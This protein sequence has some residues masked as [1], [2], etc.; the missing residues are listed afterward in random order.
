[1]TKFEEL[2]KQV[3][4]QVKAKITSDLPQEE[5]KSLTELD[6]SVDLLAEEHDKLVKAHQSLKDDYIDA[7]KSSGSRSVDDKSN[8]NENKEK[9]FEEIAQEII[10]NRK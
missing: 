3:H 2:L 6:K 5:I 7:I 4:D 1:M 10:A 9:T 8:E